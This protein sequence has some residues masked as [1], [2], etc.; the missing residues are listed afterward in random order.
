MDCWKITTSI[1]DGKIDKLFD[2]LFKSQYIKNQRVFPDDLF[3]DNLILNRFETKFERRGMKL[4][5]DI[6]DIIYQHKKANNS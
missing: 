5:H 3:A 4:G 1:Y 2:N 6:H